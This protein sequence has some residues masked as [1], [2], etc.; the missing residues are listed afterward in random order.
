MRHLFDIINIIKNFGQILNSSNMSELELYN[1]V[2][3]NLSHNKL[4]LASAAKKI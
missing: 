2:C 4:A 3:L 1:P